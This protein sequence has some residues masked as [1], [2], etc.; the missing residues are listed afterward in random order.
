MPFAAD[1][2]FA[3][4]HS[5]TQ[6]RSNAISPSPEHFDADADDMAAGLTD[7]RHL[8]DLA[9]GAL[10]THVATHERRLTDLDGQIRALALRVANLEA[11]R[12]APTKD[13][14]PLALRIDALEAQRVAMDRSDQRLLA[15]AA[16]ISDTRQTIA[17][18]ASGLRE[19]LERDAA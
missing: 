10:Q 18:L 4:R 16:D 13:M 6:H 15:L 2:S 5:Y 8:V 17:S 3:R 11:E 1:G 9:V 14:T 19:A 7:L 12:A